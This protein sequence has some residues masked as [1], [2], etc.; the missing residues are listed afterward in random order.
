VRAL[1]RLLV[2]LPFLACTIPAFTLPICQEGFICPCSSPIV[3]DV[4]GKGFHLTDAAHG[5]RFD[6]TGTNEPLQ[7]AWTAPDAANAWLAL[8][9]NGNG[10]IDNG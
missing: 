9:R 1:S 4:G 10:S 6:I 2:L 7:I 5:V 3:I 8:D